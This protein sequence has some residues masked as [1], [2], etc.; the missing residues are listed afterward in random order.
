[1]YRDL[2]TDVNECLLI[3]YNCIVL[4]DGFPVPFVPFEIII[5][6]WI[7]FGI[8]TYLSMVMPEYLT[9][10]FCIYCSIIIPISFNFII[11]TGNP[12]P[13]N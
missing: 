13:T 11:G 10:M 5:I 7:W 1:M 6:M 4:G 8:I 12:S 3:G 2:V 9:E